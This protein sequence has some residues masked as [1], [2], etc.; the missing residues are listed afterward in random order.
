MQMKQNTVYVTFSICQDSELQMLR[1]Q[2]ARGTQAPGSI[3]G[4]KK[5]PCFGQDPLMVSRVAQHPKKLVV[6]YKY[7]SFYDYPLVY[8]IK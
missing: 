6:Y 2:N 1:K 3:Y 7:D 8:Y 5:S 4:N